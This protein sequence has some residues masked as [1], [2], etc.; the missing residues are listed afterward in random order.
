[1]QL[2]Q[3]LALLHVAF[4]SRQIL[5]LSRIHQIHFETSLLQDVEYRDPVDASGLHGHGPNPALLQPIGHRLQLGCGAP[6]ATY[7]LA[8]PGGG[9]AT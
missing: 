1:M 4:A 5:R 3:P 6:K 9:T 2:H 7:R 8:V